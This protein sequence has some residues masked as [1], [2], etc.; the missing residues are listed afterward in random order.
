MFDQVSPF[1]YLDKRVNW[2][3]PDK[4]TVAAGNYK[5]ILKIIL[6]NQNSKVNYEVC[7]HLNQQV[8]RTDV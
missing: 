4:S 5:H 6:S 1:C 8:I 2:I 3:S 7:L